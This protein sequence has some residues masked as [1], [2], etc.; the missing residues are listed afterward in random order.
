M[1]TIA[2]LVS[3]KLSEAG[4]QVLRDAKNVVLE[5]R[6]GLSEDELCGIIGEYDGLIIRSGTKVTERVVEAADRLRA[7][8]R[9][10]IGVDN[11]DIPAASRK[12]IV[13]MNTPTG[14][15]VT[16]AEHALSLLTSL[17][18]R[19]PQAVSS[20]RAGKWEKSKF[21]GREI[22][23]KTLGIIGL[24]NIG[25]I[26]ADRAQG[27][28]MKVIG[29]DPVMNK[30]K[31]AE[32]GIELVSFEELLKRSDFITIHAPLT[33]ETKNLLN[34][35]AFSKMKNDVLIV[36]AARGGI[37]DELALASAIDEGIVGGAA[38]DVFTEEPIDSKHPLLER[39]AVLCTPHLGASTSEAQDR[40]AYEIAQQVI[41]Y[42]D[43][44]TI[45][46][47]I[48]VPALPAEIAERLQ[49]YCD[50]G[51]GLGSVLG[52]LEPID[53]AELRV[54]CT[55]E[56]GDLGVTPIAR[57]AL[58]GFLQQH[59]EEPVN[60][61]SAPFEAQ[62]RGIK[63][64]E[65][66]EPTDRYAS[67]VR[68]TIRGDKGIHTATGTPGGKGEPRLV[69]LEGYEIDAVLE[70]TLIVMRNLDKP[71]VIGA[72]GTELGKRNI[73]VSRM[74]VGLD[75]GSGQALALWNVEADVSDD[76]LQALGQIEHVSRVLTV[77]L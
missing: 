22:A 43:D 10:G 75:E 16:T 2:V 58:A 67:T 38:L 60:P 74:Q 8:G 28:K 64:V 35:D 77:K 44:G 33:P 53:V 1:G 29:V 65:V 40:V 18:R 19:I 12:G 69:G 31:A 24:G 48:N 3:D 36:N 59:L 13:V 42:L 4:L 27:L 11:I 56:A 57:A 37:V 63:L 20:M 72:V 15:S 62:A 46:N 68:V 70:G 73:N 21:Q 9:A 41:S 61:I 55:G 30:G 47:A 52:Q 50:V 6:P 25:R 66:K 71:G 26:V 39:D 32:L 23:H 51:H 5:Y 7:I 17:A 76:A 14:N 54:T 49:P 34:A 45:T